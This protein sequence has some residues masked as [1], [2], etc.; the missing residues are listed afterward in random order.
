[1]QWFYETLY[2]A[3]PTILDK[4]NGKPRLPLP[5]K[6]RMGKWR[7]FA[8]RAASSLIWAGDGGLLFHFILS[9]IVGRQR[10]GVGWGRDTSFPVP[11]PWLWNWAEF[12]EVKTFSR[13]SRLS[14]RRFGI[15]IKEDLELRLH[16]F[17]LYWRMSIA[18]RRQ[19]NPPVLHTSGES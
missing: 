9:K 5:P 3:R 14:Q 16:L 4:I 8:L 2:W 10:S 17:G 19:E 11:F 7:V 12:G 6:S 13:R 18:K 1:M 15:K